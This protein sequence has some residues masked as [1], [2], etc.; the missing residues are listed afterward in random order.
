MG[1]FYSTTEEKD[2]SC[3]TRK[4]VSFSFCFFA[5]LVFKNELINYGVSLNGMGS[6]AVV[7]RVSLA[8]STVVKMTIKY[9]CDLLCTYFVQGTGCASKGTSTPNCNFSL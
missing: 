2:C 7:I 3:A 6:M 9:I 1:L 8:H 5:C 4:T